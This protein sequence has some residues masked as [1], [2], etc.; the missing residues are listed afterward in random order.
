MAVDAQITEKATEWLSEKFDEQTRN[1]VKDLMENNEKE[2]V[3]CFYKN[4]EFGTGA[5]TE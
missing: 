4:L 5:P 2:L 1:Q 3:E